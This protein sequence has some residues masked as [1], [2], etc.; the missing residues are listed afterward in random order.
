MSEN[1]HIKLE[2][3]EGLQAK[4]DILYL[5]TDFLKILKSAKMYH[6]LRMQELELKIV[7]A[8]KIRQAENLIK[9]LRLLIPRPTLPKI[10]KEEK[11]KEV[12]FNVKEE[13]GET[14]LEKQL[15]EISEKLK[16]LKI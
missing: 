8:K 15:Q 4:S 7:L 1:L 13:S 2:Y 16:S 6:Q 5:Q 10:L 11:R 9:N 12:L 14:D 3:D